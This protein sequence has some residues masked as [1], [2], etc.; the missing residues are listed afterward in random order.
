MADVAV[1]GGGISGLATAWFLRQQAPDLSVALLEGADRLGGKIRTGEWM[2]VPV[3]EGPDT[4]LARVP[5][6]VELCRSLGLEDDLA[7]P[8]TGRAF[9]WTRGRLRALP[10]GHVLGVPARLGP[11][12]RS[13]LVSTAGVARAALDL[14]LPR[15]AGR[16]RATGDDLSVAEIVGHRYGREVVD[17]LVDPLLGG[18]HAGSTDRLSLASVAPVV[19]EAARGHRS[20][21]LGLRRTAGAAG[22]PPAPERPLFLGVRG[23]LGRLVDRLG[24]RLAGVDV[25]TGARVESLLPAG[26]DGRSWRLDCGPAG[27]VE[28]DGVVLTLP[29]F[30]AAALL[31]PACPQVVPDLEGITYASVV[32]ATLAYRPDAVPG[33]LDGSGFLV[34]AVDGRLLTA[35]TWLTSKWPDLARSGRV[36]LRASAGRA[37]DERALHMDD[38]ALVS[39]L[40]AELAEALGLRAAPEASMVVRWARAFPQYEVGHAARVGRIEEAVARVS[41]SVVLTGAAYHGLGIA[42]CVQQAERAA[43]R[44]LSRSGAP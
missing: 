26:R 24:E 43:T 37:G 13:G 23:G 28:A 36:L 42:A 5:W 39:R 22:A 7:A 3:E 1:V 15:D 35:C 6:A 11:L 38:D 4:F 44:I 8:A 14:V 32:T 19:A 34:P 30:A 21:L 41:P 9:V 2:G 27:A 20:L 40:H 17:R 33:A 16:G 10:A 18:I 25:R 29:A 31:G 12:A